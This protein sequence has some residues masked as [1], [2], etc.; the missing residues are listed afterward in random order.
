MK[1]FLIILL[2]ILLAAAMLVI[3]A[4]A[5]GESV[6]V[7]SSSGKPG[8]TVYVT[9]SLHGFKNVDSIAASYTGLK[10]DEDS[11]DW[12]PK[13]I[14]EEI[15]SNRA[16]C[17]FDGA[18]NLDGPV[19]SLAFTIPAEGFSLSYPI[20]IVCQVQTDSEILS[21]QETAV[22]TVTNPASSITVN[23]TQV[24]LDLSSTKTA[25]V[26]PSVSPTNHTDTLT[27][28]STNPT[29][30]TV[31]NG[32]ITAVGTG[33]ATITVAANANV[34]AACQVT[35]TCS[36]ASKTEHAAKP[37][38][39]TA[40][41]NNRYFTCD[42]CSVVLKADGTTE[43][44]VQAETLAQLP[45]SF[46]TTWSANEAQHY[47]L[48]TACNTA[49]DKAAHHTFEW[50]ITK[51]PTASENGE[52]AY[53][54]TTCQYVQ[55]T[56]TLSHLHT[57][58]HYPAKA[59]TC[60][61]TGNVEYW[62]CSHKDCS[63]KYYG[64]KDC[65]SVLDSITIPVDSSNHVHTVVKDA[66]DPTC[67]QAGSTGYTWCN[68]CEKT[69]KE[70]QTINPTGNHVAASEWKTDAN[71]H[72]HE[73][74]TSGCT[75]KLN[76]AGHSFQY[77]VTVDPTEDTT[78]LRHKECSV[79]KYS[80][81][82]EIIPVLPHQHIGIQH[83]TPKTPNCKET[84]N[85]EY[86]T[87]ASPKCS[88]EFYGDADCTVILDKVALDKDPDVHAGG[89]EIRDS[90][91]ENCFTDG[92]TGDTYCKGCGAMIEK[93]AVIKA[94][95]DHVGDGV[96]KSDA[97]NH[98][99]ICA[100]TGCGA[101]VNLKAHE[102][103][104]FVDKPATEDET[105][106][107]HEVCECGLKRNE[108]TEIPKLDHVHIGIKRKAAVAATCTKEGTVEYWTCSSSKCAGKYYG[109]SK[110]QLELETIVA[111][112]N[113]D[114]HVNTEVK[115]K[116][117]ATCAEKGYSG[118]TWCKDCKKMIKQGSEVAATGKHTPKTGYLKDEKY[119]WQECKVCNAV[120]TNSKAQHTFTWIV[121]SKPTEATT[122][123]KHEECTVCKQVRN[124][125]STIDKLTHNPQLVYAVEA[126]CTENGTKEHFYCGNC[127]RF[128]AS[129]DGKLGEQ[130]AKEDTVLEAT[131][132]NYSEEWMSDD[133]NHWHECK[134]GEAEGKE[135]HKT[136][137]VGA[138]EATETEE[139]YTG[140]TVCTVCEKVLEAGEV[141]PV[142]EA[143]PTEAPTEI[144]TDVPTTAP[145]NEEEVQNSVSGLLW[146]IP[147]ALVIL[148]VILFLIFKKRN[149]K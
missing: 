142:L 56:E 54:C 28:T 68:D 50:K 45:H 117:E 101:K 16:V 103:K 135:A 136:E 149:N 29:V 49:T 92:Y 61:A 109:D 2:T 38:S 141:I 48:C 104:W 129:D 99:Q 55:K 120:I 138:V 35:V 146:I 79:C 13:C 11:S 4:S 37:A 17:A 40:A 78:G 5:S 26:V 143:E 58:T 69:V 39:C 7:T 125:K 81:S 131:G 15:G 124:E 114:N 82:D 51:Q 147:L 134:C 130:I 107:K 10:V 108:N 22:I 145:G 97:N 67:Y 118:D 30:A 112:I 93:G 12:L 60:V 133:D 121:D 83:H 111:P 46:A 21:Y 34:S 8:E 90:A 105:G 53:A 75:T 44:S 87:C 31:S 47:Y 89:T 62:M 132:H 148:A 74:T 64:D 115:D 110:C 98:W 33:E 113:P 85:V 91:K 24:S 128:F 139:G 14:M 119:H 102:Y 59:A 76:E 42:T 66:K 88:G 70:A 140:D 27:W 73:C 86:W 6:S 63:G 127:G 84:G 43:T 72:W 23:P 1:R 25:T 52:R 144:P 96:W 9:V 65:T 116:V 36:H 106:L 57:A 41:G 123:V 77:V 32:V 94:T 3:P 126:T 95:G 137:L 100:T 20:Q 19:L 122:G 71:N 18:Q 80:L